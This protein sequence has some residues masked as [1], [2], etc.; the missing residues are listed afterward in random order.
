MSRPR[1]V[2]PADFPPL[3]G[4]SPCLAR[5]K[6][7]ADFVLHSDRPVDDGEKIRRVSEADIL[8]NSRGSLKFPRHVLRELPRLKMIA[9]CGIGYDAIDLP[10]ATEQGIVVCNVPG[11][12]ATVVAE[13]AVGLMFAVARNMAFQ[14]IEL[15][16][17]R[18]RGDLGVSLTGKQLGV[19]GTGNIGCEMIR[20][21]RAIGMKAVAWSL[22]PDPDKAAR[23]GFEYVSLDQLLQKSDVVSLH[24]RLSDQT[25]GLMNAERFAVMKH[26]SILI[27]TA[28]GAMVETNALVGALE[29][30]ALF[31][32]GLD[33]FDEEPVPADHPILRCSRVVL[34]PHTADT[35][36]EGLDVLTLGCIDNIRAFLA[37]T[38]QNVVNPEVLSAC[39][40]TD[41]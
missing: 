31:G 4:A 24:T 1:V 15:K 34:T 13:H 10:T 19:I 39:V 36:Q 20:L 7:I 11:R 38:P 21:C 29:S 6:D 33:V 32:A 5:L 12:T 3:V 30:G 2:I 16:A 8:L 37:G 17:G 41:Q 9:V 35:T 23:L 26:G 40:R 28:R 22:H 18:W 27:N 14:T 25:R